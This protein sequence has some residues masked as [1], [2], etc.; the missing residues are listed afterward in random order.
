[1]EIN[2]E[3]VLIS[4]WRSFCKTVFSLFGLFVA[5]G[6]LLLV[7]GMFSSPYE[8]DEKTTVDIL[9]DLNNELEVRPLSSPVVLRIDVHGEIGTEFLNTE[10][11]ENILVDSRRGVLGHDRVKAILLHMDT[12]GGGVTDSDNIY[13]MVKAYKAQYNVPVF[14]YV[15]GMCASG[16]MYI[17]SAA[18]KV[19][20]GPASI[21]GSVGV[22]SGPFFNVS[23]TMSRYGVQ[24]KTLTQG[25]DKDM[26][27]PYRPWKPDEDASLMATMTF[28]YQRFVDIVTQAHPRLDRDKLVN[29]Y[30]AKVYVGPEAEKLGYVEAA[31]SDYKTAV[32]DLMQQAKIDPKQP[33]QIVVLKPRIDLFTAISQ[34]SSSFLSK[35]LSPWMPAR[36]EQRKLEPF[37]YLYEPGVSP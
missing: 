36:L 17:S 28:F 35:L 23:D 6:V 21:V 24:A 14:A 16:G 22:R 25:L 5:I 34:H 8:M 10:R 9:P 1:M 37:L 20:A 15:D 3:S 30:G 4:A 7:L 18:D 32:S 19:Y 13:R 33:Y 12:P 26:M 29:V 31:D 11:V 27:N 2:R